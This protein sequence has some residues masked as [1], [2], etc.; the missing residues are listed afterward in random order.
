MQLLYDYCIR[1]ENVDMK[2]IKLRYKINNFN[3]FISEL[4]LKEEFTCPP[5]SIN[6]GCACDGPNAYCTSYGCQDVIIIHR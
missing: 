1:R 4:E 3:K 6:G 5:Y 2:S